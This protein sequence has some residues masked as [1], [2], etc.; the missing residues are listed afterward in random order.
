MGKTNPG[1]ISGTS[2]SWEN[3]GGNNEGST[4]LRI[5][6]SVTNNE[7]I[8]LPFFLKSLPFISENATRIN[9]KNVRIAGIFQRGK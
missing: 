3:L 1:N 8:K 2:I 9:D 4:I 5:E 7:V 6:N